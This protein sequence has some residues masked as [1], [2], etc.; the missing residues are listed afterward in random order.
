MFLVSVAASPVAWS[1]LALSTPL[2]LG[3]AVQ[4]NRARR[5]AR[6]VFAPLLDRLARPSDLHV[7][8]REGGLR[9]PFADLAASARALLEAHGLLVK[10]S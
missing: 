8:V 4:R 7:V 3:G 1:R 9:A 5:R 6:A 2:R 10:N